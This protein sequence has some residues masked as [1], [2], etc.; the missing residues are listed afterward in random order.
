MA[1]LLPLD[2]LRLDGDTQPRDHINEDVVKQY[3]EDMVA[4]AKFPPVTVFV[5]GS[6]HWLADGFHRDRHMISRSRNGDLMV[7]ISINTVHTKRFDSATKN[8]VASLCIGLVD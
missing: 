4:D 2:K 3:V 5:D 6:D 7:C 8:L 1:E